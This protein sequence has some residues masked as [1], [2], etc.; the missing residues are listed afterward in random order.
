M[1]KDERKGDDE[2]EVM[3]PTDSEARKRF[4]E[5][6]GVLHEEGSIDSFNPNSPSKKT[7]GADGAYVKVKDQKKDKKR[8]EV[9]S[10]DEEQESKGC[11]SKLFG[12]GISKESRNV[13]L[14]GSC[15]PPNNMSNEV[16]NR[17]YNVIT[18]LPMFLYNQFRAFF[19]M[20]FL[21][22]TVSQFFPILRVG[23][24]STDQ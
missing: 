10:D 4:A 20:F 13:F 6:G 11:L 23:K 18:F 3:T 2:E 19:N 9:K 22:I 24:L 12:G 15:E 16:K 14:K 5:Q 17:K 7:E 8:K 1:D 21:A